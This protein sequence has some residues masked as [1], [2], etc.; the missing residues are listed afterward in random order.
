MPEYIAVLEAT[1]PIAKGK[2]IQRKLA[3]KAILIAKGDISSLIKDFGPKELL[4][5]NMTL[6]AKFM[7][8]TTN[9]ENVVKVSA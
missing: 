8:L 1:K 2:L 3:E 6:E 9:S 5:E 4:L 7:P